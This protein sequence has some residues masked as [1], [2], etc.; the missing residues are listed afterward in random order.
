MAMPSS[1]HTTTLGVNELESATEALVQGI[2]KAE[3]EGKAGRLRAAFQKEAKMIHERGTLLLLKI[4]AIGVSNN[5]HSQE[6]VAQRE[7]IRAERKRLA[8][9]VQACSRR[10]AQFI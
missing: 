10:L 3:D 7:A 6:S 8:T 4:D 5:G 2:S 9:R 1:A